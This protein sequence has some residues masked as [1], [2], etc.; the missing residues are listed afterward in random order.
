M[1]YCKVAEGLGCRAFRVDK[2]GDLEAVLKKALEEEGPVLIDAI[3][4]KDDRVYPM[5]PP[6]KPISEAIDID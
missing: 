1:D 4:D 2:L 3:I 6:G 5:V